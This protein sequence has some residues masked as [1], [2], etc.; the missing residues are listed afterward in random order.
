MIVNLIYDMNQYRLCLDP[1]RD[2]LVKRGHEIVYSKNG[3]KGGAD[4][5]SPVPQHI[6]EAE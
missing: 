6:L 2:E 3:P 5:D 1:I 4:Q